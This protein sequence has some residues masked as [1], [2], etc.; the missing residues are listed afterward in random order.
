MNENA[1]KETWSENVI[2]ADADYIDRVVFDL[3]VNFE[4]M[5]GRRIPKANFGRW[6]DCVALDAGMRPYDAEPLPVTQ[7]ILLHSKE[8]KQLDNFTPASYTE[9]LDGKAFSDQLGEFC[10]SCVPVEHLTTMEDLFCESLQHI[11]QQSEVKRLMVIGDDGYYDHIK[12]ALTSLHV[13]TTTVFT[14]QPLPGGR[15]QQEMLG[16]SLMAAMGI[17]S[18]EIEKSIQ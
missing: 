3:T 5:L 9:E 17:R 14:M 7:I 13:P 15:F 8:R 16:Y 4:R 12:S 11:C 2:L 1:G 6:A 10:I 18:E